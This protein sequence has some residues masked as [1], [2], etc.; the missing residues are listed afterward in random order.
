MD[1]IFF[2]KKKKKR[3][4]NLSKEGDLFDL[5]NLKSLIMTVNLIEE[6]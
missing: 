6:V 5:K 2:L 1:K 3:K 4:L